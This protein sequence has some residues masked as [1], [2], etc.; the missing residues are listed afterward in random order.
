VF[1]ARDA[2]DRA[3]PLRVAVHALEVVSLAAAAKRVKEKFHAS[4]A[5]VVVRALLSPR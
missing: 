5:A 3:V 2:T 4:A 1:V